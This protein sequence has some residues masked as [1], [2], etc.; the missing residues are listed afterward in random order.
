MGRLVRRSKEVEV[1]MERGGRTTAACILVQAVGGGLGW[2]ALPAVMPEVARDLGLTRASSSAAFGAASLG[3]ALAAPLGGAAVDRLGPRRVAAAAMI[4]GAAACAARAWAVGPLSLSVMMLLFGLHIGFVAPSLPKALAGALPLARVARANGLA[5]LGYTLATA[6]VMLIGRT[7]LAPV[8]GGWRP[9]MLASAGAMVASAAAFYAT[10][11]DGASL[12][13]HAPLA[14]SLRMV[15]EPGMRRVG[16]MHFLLFG[17]Y[18]ALL[19]TLP[20]LLTAAGLSKGKV[21]LCI[22]V[23]LTSAGVANYAGPWVSDKI[24]SRRPLILAGAVTA[25][26]ALLAFAVVPKGVGWPLLAVAALG[27]G[28]FAPLL[29]TAPLEMPRVGPA[30]AGA[31]LGLLMLVGQ[32]GGFVVPVLSGVISQGMG[33]SAGMAFLALVHLAIVV[34]ALGLASAPKRTAT[35]AASH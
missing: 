28:S 23:W 18:L 30:R 25:G 13:A 20:Q 10:V 29:L 4:F 14:D 5:L 26:A 32:A 17:G 2:S 19:A 31:A 3:I 27:G 21:G 7:V 22:A 24:G 11:R 1:T 8:L 12:G 6:L 9:L 16:A 35:L 15:R 34:P 33:F